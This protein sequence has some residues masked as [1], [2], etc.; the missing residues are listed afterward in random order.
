[1]I[2]RDGS[3][4]E[5]GERVKPRGPTL[6]QPDEAT[7]REAASP[8]GP[9]SSEVRP[10][11]DRKTEITREAPRRTALAHEPPP[12]FGAGTQ[13]GHY[14]IIRP[15]GRGGM[16]E[17]HLA[18]D[19]RLGRRVALK[20]LLKVDAERLARFKVEARATAQ[21]SHENI[22]ALYDIGEHEGLPFMALEYVPGKS[23]LTWFKERTDRD[24]RCMGLPPARAA[25]LMLPVA[26]AL[27]CAHAAGIVHRDLKPGT[28]CWPIAGRCRCWTSASP[29][30]W[31]R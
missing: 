23:L 17:V 25:E 18:R 24:G 16:G 3:A 8:G 7:R 26:R 11:G 1:M 31:R 20:F 5:E 12:R 28:S 30:C 2:A 14:E 6:A 21:L 22:V 4:A 13:V 29:S 19:T 15:L 9:S 27:A 10:K